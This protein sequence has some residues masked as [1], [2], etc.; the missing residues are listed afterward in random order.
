MKEEYSANI[1]EH[2]G[3]VASMIDELG[4]VEV[5]DGA[6]PQDMNQRKVSI[7]QA[8]KALIICGL[9]FTNHRLYLAGHFFTNKPTERLIGAD[10]KAEHLNDDVL[11]RALDALYE[12]GVTAMFHWISRRSELRP[13]KRPA[14]TSAG[15]PR[16]DLFRQSSS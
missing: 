16:R 10:I 6:I 5:I 4:I 8:I 15:R 9:G 12:Y 14:P 13:E 2:L 1:I 11:G 3:L 7:G